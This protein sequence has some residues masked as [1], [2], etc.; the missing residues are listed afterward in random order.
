MSMISLAK[1]DSIEALMCQAPPEARRQVLRALRE[2]GDEVVDM[3]R[4]EMIKSEGFEW[5]VEMGFHIVPSI[6]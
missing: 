2:M 3:I 1:M 4:D 5:S 6:Q